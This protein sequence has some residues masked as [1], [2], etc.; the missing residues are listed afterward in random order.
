MQQSPNKLRNERAI[1]ESGEFSL[2]PAAR[3]REASDLFPGI[4]LELIDWESRDLPF[5]AANTFC[6]SSEDPDKQRR[7]TGNRVHKVSGRLLSPQYVCQIRR[8]SENPKRSL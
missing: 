3:E 4:H 5:L 8:R 2:G 6:H 1:R 7:E